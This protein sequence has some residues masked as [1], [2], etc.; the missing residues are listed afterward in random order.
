MFDTHSD[1]ALNKLDGEAIVCPCASGE[2]IRLTREDFSSEEEF[3][4]WKE[5][6]D[7]DYHDTE[8]AGRKFY[9]K[10]N[11]VW[12]EYDELDPEKK[13]AWLNLIA[14]AMMDSVMTVNK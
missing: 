14:G 13:S 2:H 8:K 1:Y 11:C 9:D 7:C 3:Q 6:S 12:T 4:H 5:W 10:C